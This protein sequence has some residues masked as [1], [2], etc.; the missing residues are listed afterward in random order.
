MY[1]NFMFK[2]LV[3]CYINMDFKL[4]IDH[5]AFVCLICRDLI[6]RFATSSLMKLATKIELPKYFRGFFVAPFVDL[7]TIY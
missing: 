1:P 3:H 2:T 4:G 5:A 7:Q 6:A